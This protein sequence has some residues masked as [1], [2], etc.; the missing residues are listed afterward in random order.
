MSNGFFPRRLFASNANVLLPRPVMYVPLQSG[1]KGG[2]SDTQLEIS[3][4][5]VPS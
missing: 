3:S 2:R 4:N 5:R 1:R